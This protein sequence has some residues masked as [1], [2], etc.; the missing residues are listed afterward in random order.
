MGVVTASKPAQ[1]G[2]PK[3]EAVARLTYLTQKAFDAQLGDRIVMCLTGTGAPTADTNAAL[4]TDGSRGGYFPF[5]TLYCDTSGPTFYIKT[6]TL[7]SVGT[8]TAIG[9]IANLTATGAELSVLHS[10]SMTAGIMA[11]L[12]TLTATAD[13]LNAIADVSANTVTVTEG[14][15]TTAITAAARIVKVTGGTGYSGMVIPVPTAGEVGRLKQITLDTITSGT[16]VSTVSNIVVGGTG[17]TTLTLTNAGDCI[18][19]IGIVYGA[20]YR[21]KVLAGGALVS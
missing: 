18:V 17:S 15:K 9:V 20:T 5:G 1:A 13:E 4:G 3:P 12:A 14:T 21:W 6:N 19:L 16:V 2:N 10:S 7:A 8:W 11:D